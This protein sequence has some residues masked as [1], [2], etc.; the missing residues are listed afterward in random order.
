MSAEFTTTRSPSTRTGTST[1]EFTATSARRFS[2]RSPSTASNGSPLK[3]SAIQTLRANG[4]NGLSKSFIA[5]EFDPAGE[6]TGAPSEPKRPDGIQ[7]GPAR[8]DQTALH[9]RTRVSQTGRPPMERRTATL[10]LL[11]AL[12]GASLSACS[13]DE[14]PVGTSVAEAAVHARYSEE[15]MT[16]FR[17]PSEDELKKKLDPLQYE[18]TQH[19][20]TEPPFRNT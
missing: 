5:P 12:T 6:A 9:S 4:L 15:A 3:R 18:V 7:G 20:G 8:V 14:A 19:E 1:R 10:L 16:N 2:G 17:K 13:R 11:L